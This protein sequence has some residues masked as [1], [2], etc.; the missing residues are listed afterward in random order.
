LESHYVLLVFLF[1]KSSFHFLTAWPD[2]MHTWI[3]RNF[4]YILVDLSVIFVSVQQPGGG[5]N[6]PL[7]PPAR[8]CAM[9]IVGDLLRKVGVSVYYQLI[10]RAL[11]SDWCIHFSLFHLLFCICSCFMYYSDQFGTNLCCIYFCC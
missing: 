4:F 6:I 5:Q 11:H 2:F 3:T 10:C 1:C 7:T 8:I 9:N